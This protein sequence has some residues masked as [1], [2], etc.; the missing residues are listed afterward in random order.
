RSPEQ[1]RSLTGALLAFSG[2]KNVQHLVA[3]LFVEPKTTVSTKLLLLSILGRC[4]IEQLPPSWLEVLRQAIGQE[5]QSV[6][7]GAVAVVKLRN[8]DRFDR[9]LTDLSRNP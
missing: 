5:D 1:E 9:Q 6:K 3:E 8:L 7:R 4:R 2:E